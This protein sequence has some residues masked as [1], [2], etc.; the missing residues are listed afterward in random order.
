MVTIFTSVGRIATLSFSLP[1]ILRFLKRKVQEVGR[2]YVHLCMYR[3]YTFILCPLSYLP[4][5]I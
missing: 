3:G 4:A 1:Q 5:Y 2:V